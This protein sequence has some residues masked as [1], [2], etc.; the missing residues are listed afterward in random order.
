MAAPRYGPAHQALRRQ[1]A[2]R[3]AAGEVA[4]HAVDCLLPSRLI[5]PGSEWHLGHNR[6]GTE[7]TGPEHWLCNVTDGARRS[8]VQPDTWSID[9]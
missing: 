5:E 9:W 1:W 7:H 2:P 6:A 8:H 4:C 3:V